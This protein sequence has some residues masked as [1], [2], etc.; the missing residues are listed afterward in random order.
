MSEGNRWFS[1][2]NVMRAL[3]D[4]RTNILLNA[5]IFQRELDAAT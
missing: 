4:L 2:N 1:S 5:K 3:P